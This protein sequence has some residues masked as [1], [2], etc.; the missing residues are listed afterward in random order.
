MELLPSSALLRD[1]PDLLNV[2]HPYT[3]DSPEL[4]RYITS[5]E[6]T[7]TPKFFRACQY[8]MIDPPIEQQV[9]Q[10]LKIHRD[11][12]K[13][14]LAIQLHLV[15]A[16]VIEWDAYTDSERCRYGILWGISVPNR[17]VLCEYARYGHLDVVQHIMDHDVVMYHYSETALRAASRNGHLS[18]V[19]YLVEQ[20]VNL[21]TWSETPLRAASAYGYLPIVQYLVEHGADMHACDDE[22]LR[23]ASRE[24]HVPVVQCLVDHGAD[25]HALGRLCPSMGESARS[26]AC[27]AIPH[28]QRCECACTR[29]LGPSKCE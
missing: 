2:A 16:S 26:F 23:E 28:S 7:W 20:G 1:D 12:D 5:H 14:D 29:Q 19:R 22:A 3:F 17:C 11:E 18:V 24:G 6:I 21:H 13:R 27:R 4:R 25:V 10:Y 8:F 9:L 15:P